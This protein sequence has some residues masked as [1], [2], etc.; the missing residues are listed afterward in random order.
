MS[1]KAREYYWEQILRDI[2]KKTCTPIIGEGIC[3]SYIPPSKEIA[4][5]WAEEYGY[6]LEDSYQLSRVAQYLAIENKQESSPKEILFREVETINPPDFSTKEL[7]NT[8][9]SVLADLN[10]PIYITTSYDLFMEA[11]LKSK[12]KSPISEFCRW[13][14]ALSDLAI[15]SVL[16]LGKGSRGAKY[17]TPTQASPIVYHL[18]GLYSLM[19][20]YRPQ[21]EDIDM[22]IPQ[23]L[24]L[25]EKDYIDFIYTLG[26]L[27][28][29]NMFPA[30][31]RTAI[32]RSSL[33]FVGFSLDDLS[34]RVTFQGLVNSQS[35]LKEMSLSVQLPPHDK[36][37]QATKYLQEYT[38]QMF[39]IQVYW[40]DVSKF[41]EELRTRWDNFKKK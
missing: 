9:H 26:R 14:R 33:L 37:E 25:T 23:S 13:N 5:K 6:P 19:G 7:E 10:L 39:K 32:S 30:P 8:P 1:Q 36:A 28:D 27:G 22:D 21:G 29:E 24:V 12:G 40:G 2:S 16:P 18:F 31:I 17:H 41:C 3:A 15:P 4:R 20:E 35:R 38:R 11:A 34:F